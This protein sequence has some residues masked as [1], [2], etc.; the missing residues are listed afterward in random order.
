MISG[1]VAGQKASKPPKYE[2]VCSSKLSRLACRSRY[3]ILVRFW[4]PQSDTR[5]FPPER[6]GALKMEIYRCPNR[7]GSTGDVNV[8]RTSC[9]R[10]QQANPKKR[11][12]SHFIILKI[13]RSFFDTI[14]CRTSINLNSS[15]F[16]PLTKQRSSRPKTPQKSFLLSFPQNPDQS[17]DREQ[18]KSARALELC[19]KLLENSVKLSTK[20]VEIV[21]GG[22]QKG[23][24]RMDSESLIA[25]L[26]ESAY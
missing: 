17:G 8:L 11:L 14:C 26:I 15:S 20:L 4:R 10:R 23:L 3:H 16:F 6:K 21:G 9:Q 18:N 5:T 2:I 22:E 24:L 7:G 25:R 1:R 19:Y 12:R 13:K